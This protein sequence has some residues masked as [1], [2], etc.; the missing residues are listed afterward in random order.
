[1]EFNFTEILN[2]H[3]AQVTIGQYYSFLI[4]VDIWVTQPGCDLIT[5]CEIIYIYIYTK[6]HQFKYF[7]SRV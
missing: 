5:Y 3:E 7:G 1:M 6:I 2:K 4:I